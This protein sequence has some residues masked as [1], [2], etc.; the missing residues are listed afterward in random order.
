VLVVDDDSDVRTL[1]G[2]LLRGRGYDV[3]EVSDGNAALAAVR[4]EPP[5]VVLLDLVL[6]GTVDGWEVLRAMKEDPALAAIPICV[7]S[8]S[9]VRL[10]AG[11]VA[12]KKPVPFSELRRVVE[13]FCGVPSPPAN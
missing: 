2:D 13:Q 8:G 10:P 7:V 4:K 9:P 5:S 1:M 6:P 11:T 3:E 12:L